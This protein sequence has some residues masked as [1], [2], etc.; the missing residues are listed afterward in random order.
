MITGYATVESAVEAM[1]QGAFYY[2][3]KPFKLDIIRKII[4]E[5]DEKIN[6]KKEVKQLREQLDFHE[7]INIIT[8]SSK[9]LKLLEIARQISP[10]NC[11]VLITGESGTGKE[12]FARYIHL[13]SLRKNRS[14]LAVNCGAFTEELLSNELLGMKR[15]FYRGY[16]I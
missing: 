15:S 11:S 14:F 12:L 9:M 5:A 4:K 13:N 2:I 6:L 10:T 8:Q 1:K 7:K 3:S 16:H